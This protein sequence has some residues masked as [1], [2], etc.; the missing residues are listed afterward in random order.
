MQSVHFRSWLAATV[1]MLCTFV[2]LVQA[3]PAFP[4]KP[5]KFL[6]GFGP[7]SGTDIL[8][9]IVA[10]EMAAELKQPFVVEN[11]AGASSQL[12]AVAVK[13]AVADGYTLLFSASSPMVVNPHVYKTLPYDPLQDFTAIGGVGNYPFVLA[14]DAK[15]PIRT[16]QEFVAY[17]KATDTGKM[18]YAYGTQAVRVPAE[19]LNRLL[20]L[21]ATGIPYKSSPDAMTDVIGGRIQFLV[22]DLAAAKTLIQSGRLRAIAVTM[23]KRSD[24]VPE[25]PTIEESLELRDFDLSAFA[26][27]FGPAKMPQDVVEKLSLTMLKVIAKPE[28]RQKIAAAGAEYS[29]RDSAAMSALVQ[30]S[31][32]IWGKKVSDAGILPE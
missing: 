2:Q 15:L 27:L 9:R 25:L 29:P 1:V 4:N 28:V 19:A 31:Y 7:G 22:I 18:N 17:A 21:G 26:G 14:V 16:P 23:S 30:R 3:E 20:K 11:R 10:D 8:A 12:A 32:G 6:V 5:V 13:I 24:L